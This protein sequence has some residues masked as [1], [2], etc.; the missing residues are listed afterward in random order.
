MHLTYPE[1][2][3]ETGNASLRLWAISD[4]GVGACSFCDNRLLPKGQVLTWEA[5]R[6]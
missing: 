4:L 5:V 2:E 3:L 6:P 1:M